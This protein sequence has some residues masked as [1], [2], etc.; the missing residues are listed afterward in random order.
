MKYCTIKIKTYNLEEMFS[1][2]LL[3]NVFDIVKIMRY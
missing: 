1:Q 2:I 3:L